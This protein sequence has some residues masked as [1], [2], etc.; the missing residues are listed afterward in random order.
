MDLHQVNQRKTPLAAFSQRKRKPSPPAEA[1]FTCH[2]VSTRLQI[3]RFADKVPLSLKIIM[4]YTHHSYLPSADMA[5]K[6]L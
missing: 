2:V 1:E 5:F 6:L 3:S 4:N